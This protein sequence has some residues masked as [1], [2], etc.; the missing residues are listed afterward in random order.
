MSAQSENVETPQPN[1]NDWS[2]VR[3]A[4]ALDRTLLAWV[5]TALTLFGFGFTLARFVHSLVAQGYLQGVPPHYP[6]DIGITL[7]VLGVATLAGGSFEYVRLGR[8]LR[9]KGI[10]YSVSLI[11]AIALAILGLTL[12]VCLLQEF[13]TI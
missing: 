11:V 6:K 12:I 8:K 13:K 5:R 4:L 1:E 7:M 2:R 10:M 9:L 3:T